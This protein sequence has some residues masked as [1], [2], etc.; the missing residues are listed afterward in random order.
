MRGS[1][2][3]R[4]ARTTVVCFCHCRATVIRRGNERRTEG[5][6]RWM[7]LRLVKATNHL[8]FACTRKVAFA[9]T[10]TTLHNVRSSSCGPRRRRCRKTARH[11]LIP[12]LLARQV[13]HLVCSRSKIASGRLMTMMMSGGGG[14]GGGG[15]ARSNVE[16][17]KWIASGK[18]RNQIAVNPVP[19]HFPPSFSAPAVQR[20]SHP[21]P[22]PLPIDASAWPRFQSPTDL[23]SAAVDLAWPGLGFP[24]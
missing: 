22:L 23:H 11:L 8:S 9:T 5:S 4:S 12:N 18:R 16:Y 6:D 10:T 2:R 3:G 7:L 13:R 24:H 20:L 14:D 21:H 1:R 15:S 19:C 17:Q